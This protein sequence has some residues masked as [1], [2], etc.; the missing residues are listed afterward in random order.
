MHMKCAM[1]D[2]MPVISDSGLHLVS[3]FCGFLIVLINTVC[4]CI[5]L[6]LNSKFSHCDTVWAFRFYFV[7]SKNQQQVHPPKPCD[8]SY[9]SLYRKPHHF[10]FNSQVCWWKWTQSLKKLPAISKETKVPLCT[11]NRVL[12]NCRRTLMAC[13]VC[14]QTHLSPVT[15]WL[16]LQV[17]Y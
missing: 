7:Y 8:I 5:Q 2:V 16:N 15:P 12:Q 10:R 13:P 4:I 11:R 9:E 14:Q 1:W 3:W 6:S 17:A